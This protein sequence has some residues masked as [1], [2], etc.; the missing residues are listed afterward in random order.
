[1]YR[2]YVTLHTGLT[3]VAFA[4]A[5]VWIIISAVRHSTAQSNCEEE[6]FPSSGSSGVT[7]NLGQNMCNV[8]AWIDVGLMS[9]AW[10]FFAIVQVWFTLAGYSLFCSQSYQGYFYAIVSS[11]GASQ[12]QDHEKYDALDN[13]TKPL[14]DDIP[15]ADRGDPW[16]SRASREFEYDQYGHSRNTSTASTV[17]AVPPVAEA[18]NP[19]YGDYPSASYIPY[20]G[21]GR[22]SS[23][24]TTVTQPYAPYSS[25]MPPV[26]DYYSRPSGTHDQPGIVL[27]ELPFLALTDALGH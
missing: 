25:E 7:S 21:L 13:P 24:K 5:A 6:F 27:V 9:G 12:R 11:Y 26:G 20:G 10:V 17:E 22:Q 3:C 23:K 18:K 8:F 19:G 4:I 16:D 14:T 15:M 1:M 2:R